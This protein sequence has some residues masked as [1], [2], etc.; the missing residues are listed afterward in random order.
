MNIARLLA[1]ATILFA[2]AVA[3]YAQPSGE[4]PAPL[5]LRHPAIAPDGAAIAFT[6]RG[7]IYLVDAEGG[8]AV[9]VTSQGYYSYGAV[10]SPD[11]EK[12]AFASDINGDDDVYVADFSGQLLRQTWSSRPEQPTSFSPDGQSVLFNAIRLGDPVASVQAPLSGLPQLYSVSLASGRERL[13]MPNLAEQASWSA[14][15]TR[16]LY[17]QDRSADPKER[18]HRVASNA[19]Q[20]WIYD[21]TTGIHQPLFAEHIDTFN[22]VWGPGDTAIFYL[23]EESGT[24]NVWRHDLDTGVN[25]QLTHFSG[26]PVSSLSV[27]S[28]GDVAFA[29]NGAIHVLKHGETEPRAIE[30]IVPEQIMDQPHRQITSQADTFISSPNGLHFAAII[31]ADIFLLDRAG[32]ARQ[33]TMTPSEE[34]DVTFSPDGSK[35]VYAAQRDNRWGIYGVDLALET[36]GDQLALAYEE[37]PIVADPDSN[38]FQPGF[39]PDGTKLAFIAE[40]REVK[41]F[42]FETD[43]VITLFDPSDYNTSYRDGDQWYIWSPTSLDLA[44][45]WRTIFGSP[46]QHIGIVAADGSAPIEPINAAIADLRNGVWSQDGT[47][48]VL[49]TLQFGLRQL[50]S[51]AVMYDLY[52]MFLSHQSRRDFIDAYEGNPPLVWPQEDQD[53]IAEPYFAPLRY[54]VDTDR[55][56]LLE[57][58][59]SPESDAFLTLVPLDDFQS[60][61]MVNPTAGGIEIDILDLMTTDVTPLTIIE[62]PG[63]SAANY[64]PALNAVDVVTAEGVLTVSLSD[65]NQRSFTP[66]EITY[67]YLPSARRAAAFEQAWADI[68]DMYYRAD[69]EGRDWEAIGQYYRSLLGSV[70]S[71]RELAD[72][73]RA[74]TGELSASHLFVSYRAPYDRAWAPNS[75]GS[76]GV[77][78]DYAYEGE[79]RRIAEI[80][81]FGPLDRANIGINPGDIIATINGIPVPDAGGIDRLL[82]GMVGRQVAIGLIDEE[83]SEPRLVTTTP[84][85]QGREAMLHN[86]YWVDTRRTLV[87]QMSNGCIAYQYVPAMDNESYVATYGRLISASKWARAALIDVRSNTGG[88]LHRQ[89]LNLLTGE[90]FGIL[91]REDRQWDY[92]PADRWHMPSAVLVDNFAYS[93]GSIFPQ[94]YQDAGVGPLV[95]DRLLNTGTSVNFVNSRILPGLQ[96]A[97]PVLPYRRLDGSYYENNEIEPDILAAFDPN[98]ANKGIDNQLEAA[99]AALMDAIGPET[100]CFAFGAN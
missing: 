98:L 46:A 67:S 20:I 12:L 76:L 31:N 29:Y 27:S 48:L 78:I 63:I 92:L 82:E 24:L 88:N 17:A 100:N 74:M 60:L 30:V 73:I 32:N 55:A 52:Q 84:V 35:L 28:Q 44:V 94:A 57:R 36:N 18:Q 87:N 42:D 3:G 56:G 13:V 53:G 2:S 58:R 1:T 66:I 25:T 69:L 93:D 9:P 71:D 81:P 45:Q 40:R 21:T 54:A 6:F 85:Y 77:F 11:S 7:Q 79:G 59:L 99:V 95:G 89:L 50:D 43:T 90:A 39:S 91:G 22:P 64:V 51:N 8:L 26:R 38:A 5:W 72:I 65:P 4:G 97:I 75:T 34:R 80:L 33:I 62:M 68:R 83:A 70:A 96:Y 41:V 49:R 15:G 23:S 61:L 16:L 86:Q 47:H 14:D 37:V 19:R 10:W